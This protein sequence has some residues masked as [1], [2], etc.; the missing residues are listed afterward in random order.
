MSRFRSI[1]VGIVIALATLLTWEVGA[2]L[3]KHQ[4]PQPSSTATV[5]VV[6]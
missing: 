3:Q 4:A 5:P 1:L 6:P 2:S